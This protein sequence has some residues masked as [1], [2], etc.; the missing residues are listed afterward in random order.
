MALAIDAS[1]P[2]LANDN[3]SAGSI[4]TAAFTAPAGS[5]LW[6]FSTYDAGSGFVSITFSSSP[7]LTWV[8]VFSATGTNA[9]CFCA[10]ADVATAVSRTVTSALVASSVFSGE[11]LYVAVVTGGETTPLINSTTTKTASNAGTSWL[12]NVAIVPTASN[13]MILAAAAGFSGTSAWTVGNTPDSS[14]GPYAQSLLA[15]WSDAGLYQGAYWR[16]TPLSVSGNTYTP[17][18][19]GSNEQGNI[20]VVEIRAGASGPTT[21]QRWG[22]IKN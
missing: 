22:R 21:G 16:I 3:G 18:P 2:P 13:S 8:P 17:K 20:G 5:R 7:S 14:P 12:P 9:W 1:S 15:G 6:A 4:T 19:S 10:Y 11:S